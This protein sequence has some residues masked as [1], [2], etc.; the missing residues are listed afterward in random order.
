MAS[1]STGTGAPPAEHPRAGAL[2]TP[3]LETKAMRVT[4]ET[5]G[6]LA[7]ATPQPTARPQVRAKFLFVGDEKLYVRGV[8]YGGFRPDEDGVEFRPEAVERDF[9]RMAA[10]GANAVRTYTVPPRWLL[11]AAWRHGLWVMVGLAWEQHVAFLDGER[12]GAIEQ[13]VREAVRACAGH[14]AVLAYA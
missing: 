3:G 7:P 2:A 5:Q 9:E 1:P 12:A 13:R 10:N 6:V 14:P 8:T 4:V 11:D